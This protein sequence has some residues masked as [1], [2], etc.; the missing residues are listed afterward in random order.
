M[1][2][3]SRLLLSGT[4]SGMSQNGLGNR[5]PICLFPVVCKGLGLNTVQNILSVCGKAMCEQL[6]FFFNLQKLECKAHITG[7]NC[8][9]LA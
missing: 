3:E 2:G 1:V 7:K 6:I 5:L 9:A 8:H 4:L